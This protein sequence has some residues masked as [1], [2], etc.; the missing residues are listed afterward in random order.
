MASF[1]CIQRFELFIFVKLC[2]AGGLQKYLFLSIRDRSLITG[3]GGGG[4]G[5][6]EKEGEVM[7]EKGGGIFVQYKYLPRM[8]LLYH[9]T[10]RKKCHS[11]QS[12]DSI[13]SNLSAWRQ[14]WW[15]LVG[16]PKQNLTD[17]FLIGH[18]G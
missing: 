8:T 10:Y 13:F 9:K 12:R 1:V 11:Q 16:P 18:C 2:H 14:L 5:L 7:H 3:E 17:V 6:V 15:R 4:G